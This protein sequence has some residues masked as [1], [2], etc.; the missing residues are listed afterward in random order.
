VDDATETSTGTAAAGGRRGLGRLG[1]LAIMAVTAVVIAATAVIA[2]QP[3]A[4][5]QGITTTGVATGAPP[6]VGKPAPDFLARTIDG[7]SIRL[8]ELKGQAVWVTFGATWCQPCRAE[9]PDIQATYDKFKGEGLAVVAVYIGEESQ[10]VLDY[11]DRVRLTY[12]RIADSLTQIASQYRILGIPSHFFVDRTG[13]LREMR[14]GA[15]D[16]AAM[17]AA[18]RKIL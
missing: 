2:N 13:I 16:L 3:P 17:E 6:E 18:V 8:S 14:I 11:T 9:N 4:G 15:M 1:N 7:K 5:V 10:T 12:P